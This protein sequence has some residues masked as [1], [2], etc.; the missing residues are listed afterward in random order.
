MAHRE[1]IRAYL[2]GLTVS[3]KVIDWGSGSKPVE[4]YVKG[5]ANFVTVDK[6]PLVEPDILTDIDRPILAKFINPF[7]EQLADYA[8]CMEVLEH[9]TNP[10]TVLKNIYNN[11]KVSGRLYLSIPSVS[12]PEHGEEDYLRFTER[13]L[14][15]LTETAGFKDINIWEI[16][17]GY[18]ME[19]VK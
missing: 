17:Q 13:G 8:F 16:D 1:D 2:E 12:Y 14:R 5:N 18:L 4:N 11:L 3:G 9:T 7:M 15:L 19:A 10:L 6:N